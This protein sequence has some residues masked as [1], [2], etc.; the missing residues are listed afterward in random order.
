MTIQFGWKPVQCSNDILQHVRLCVMRLLYTVEYTTEFFLTGTQLTNLYW[1]RG[2]P[3]LILL[4]QLCTRP[5]KSVLFSTMYNDHTTILVTFWQ[6]FN[7][8]LIWRFGLWKCKRDY[9]WYD[10]DIWYGFLDSLKRSDAKSNNDF[11]RN[12]I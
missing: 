9:I 4:L 12:I 11:Y 5:M 7:K 2:T 3:R 1:T 6:G 8:D 10:M